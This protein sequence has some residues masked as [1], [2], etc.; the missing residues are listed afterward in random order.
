MTT[1]ILANLAD[2]L[3]RIR[4]ARNPNDTRG[5]GNLGK[6]NMKDPFG[7]D[8]DSS[9]EKRD[10]G[11]PT[12]ESVDDEVRD[13]PDKSDK[14]KDREAKGNSLDSDGDRIK[15]R[16]DT[17]DDNDTDDNDLIMTMIMIIKTM[18][19]MK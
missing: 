4:W 17:D 18:I 3:N 11:R 19:M 5:Q 9:R 7:D 1:P 15:D 13:G 10:R 14:N 16:K 8:K 6:P 12:C 2:A